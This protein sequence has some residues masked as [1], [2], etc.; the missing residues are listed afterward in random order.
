MSN[1]P[2]CNPIANV[3][4]NIIQG[5]TRI[6]QLGPMEKN[7]KVGTRTLLGFTKSNKGRVECCLG[8]RHN[9]IR[10]NYVGSL[11]LRNINVPSTR[12]LDAQ[13]S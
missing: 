7:A 2:Q 8:P 1:A 10:V 9:G 12:V 5:E 6:L 11:L 4:E 13:S 3:V